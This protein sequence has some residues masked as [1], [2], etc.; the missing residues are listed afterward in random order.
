LT[1]AGLV[2]SDLLWRA[3]LVV[4]LIDAPLLVLVARRVPS[5]LFGRLPWYLAGAAFLVFASIWG[6]CGSV[7]F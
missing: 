3:A 5:G 4:A 1:E 2:S 6:A 7:F